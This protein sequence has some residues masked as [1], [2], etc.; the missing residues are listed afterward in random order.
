M[1]TQAAAQRWA[2]T[3][4]RAWPLQ[5][6]ESI[7]ELQAEDGD[8]WASL[9]R[10]L[11]GR[12][13]LRS[14][15]EECFAEETQPAEAW[16]DV[17]TVDGARASVEYWVIMCINGEPMTVSGCTVLT[18]DDRGLV[19]VARDYSHVLQ[20]HHERPSQAFAC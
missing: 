7:V 6:V 12:A 8:H 15:L 11:R 18:F 19:K 20:E 14:Y 1:Q 2:K 16:F 17:P 9:F 13:G 4:A 3:W 5:D 10:P